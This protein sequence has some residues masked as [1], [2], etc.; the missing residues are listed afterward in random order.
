MTWAAMK[1]SPT[2]VERRQAVC[3]RMNKIWNKRNHTEDKQTQKRLDR[4]IDRM[5]RQEAPWLKDIAYW[6]Y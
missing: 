1:V 4:E 2:E 3:V 6:L 5:R